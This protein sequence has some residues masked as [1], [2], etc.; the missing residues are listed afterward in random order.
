MIDTFIV[1]EIAVYRE[2]L[3][4]ALHEHHGIR[5]VATAASCRHLDPDALHCHTAT[6]L[7]DTANLAQAC[8]AIRGGPRVVVVGVGESEADIVACAES[9]AM[10]YV[11]TTASLADLAATIVSVA[12]D[13]LLCPPR[14]AGALIRR[15]GVL[16][17][18][19]REDRIGG[20][21]TPREQEVLGLLTEGLSN[22]E[23]AHLLSITVATAK[24]H[25]H[26]ILEKLE[27][28]SRSEAC[29][30]AHPR[31]WPDAHP[32]GTMV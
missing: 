4:Q 17:A 3:A 25:V 30:W 22:R 15:V 29:A 10:G 11:T 2:A 7:V 8:A 28:S 6:L 24:N 32:G 23:I 13:E 9:G 26:N 12:R 20:R 5:V 16:A 31:E 27:V 14:V 19:A 1:A 18:A 21:L